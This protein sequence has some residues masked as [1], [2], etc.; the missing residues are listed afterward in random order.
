MCGTVPS[1][2]CTGNH[3]LLVLRKLLTRF[4]KRRE[5]NSMLLCPISLCVSY[6]IILTPKVTTLD[7][8]PRVVLLVL[9]VMPPLLWLLLEVGRVRNMTSSHSLVDS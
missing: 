4:I 7:R 1:V 2:S 9:M 5:L 8:L 6:G 3:L